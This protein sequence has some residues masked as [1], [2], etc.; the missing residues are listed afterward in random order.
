MSD[1]DLG[2][3]PSTSSILLLH[4]ISGDLETKTDYSQSISYFRH[5][6]CFTVAMNIRV[7]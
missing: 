5:Q 2:G 6:K 7:I 1:S 4:N 3:D